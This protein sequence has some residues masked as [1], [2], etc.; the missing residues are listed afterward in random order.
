MAGLANRV[1]QRYPS[2]SASSFRL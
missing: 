1:V 2:A